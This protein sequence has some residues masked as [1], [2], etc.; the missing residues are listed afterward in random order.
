MTTCSRCA[1]TIVDSRPL[2]PTCG[3]SL[4]GADVT[5]A[6]PASSGGA[7][8]Q[9]WPTP[10]GPQPAAPPSF[11]MPYAPPSGADSTPANRRLLAGVVAIVAIVVIVVVAAVVLPRG[12]STPKPLAVPPAAVQPALASG[13][14]VGAIQSSGPLTPASAHRIALAWFKRRDVARFT[15]DDTA[16]S[17]LE[18]GVALRVDRAFTEQIR[19]GCDPPHH[20]HLVNAVHVVVPNA[21]ARDFLAQFDVTATNHESAGYTVV[22]AHESSGWKGVL[23]ELDNP[24]EFIRAAAGHHDLRQPVGRGSSRSLRRT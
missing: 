12:A 17:A 18:S 22:L 19:C 7:M 5:E 21:H 2:C 6:T 24:H 9:A 3:A 23:I 14:P 16:L 10:V 15:N 4:T 1:T 20:M 13:A 11:A 8:P